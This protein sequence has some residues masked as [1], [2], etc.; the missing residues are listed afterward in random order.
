MRFGFTA[1]I[2]LHFYTKRKPHYCRPTDPCG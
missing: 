2:G 1:S